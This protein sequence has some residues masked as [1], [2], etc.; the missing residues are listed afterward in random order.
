MS[1]TNIGYEAFYQSNSLTDIYYQGTVLQW[2]KISI[3]SENNPL[4]KATLHCADASGFCGDEIV[5][6]L[7]HNGVLNISGSG[8]MYDYS[9]YS[10]SP[11]YNNKLVTSITI[12]EGVITIGE[13][14]FDSCSNLTNVTIP[15]TTTS[16]GDWAFYECNNLVEVYYGGSTKQWQKVTIDSVSNA[17]L[18]SATLHCAP[19]FTITINESINGHISVDNT[20]PAEGDLVSLIIEPDSCY[21]LDSLTVMCGESSVEISNNSFTMPSGNVDITATFI[22]NNHT[23]S[24]H[25]AIP[26]T[27][28]ATG[29]DAYWSCD[30][31]GRLFSD[32]EGKNEIEEPIELP[33]TSHVWGEA[34]YFWSPDNRSITATHV[35]NIDNSHKEEITVGVTAVITSPTERTRGSAAYTS[36]AF[37]AEGFTV[38]RKSIAIP[39]LRNMSVLYL[40]NL[41]TTI[42]DE[43][44]AGIDC[45]AIVI[46]TGCTSVGKHAFENCENLLYVKVPANTTIEPDAFDGCEDVVVD[47]V[48]E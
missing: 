14:A 18:I 37:N 5:W 23:L 41:L 27:C 19:T 40:P 35:C 20:S 26:A 44:F 11:W 8:T 45:E 22:M 28:L 39:M 3:S 33:K 17:P 9:V 25:E 48:T 30:V 15:V 12:S 2:E 32:E 21:G 31:C 38:Q 16:I 29:I 7:D 42:E 43:A 1:V 24:L 36:E 10:P 13:S 34:S 6:S 4:S 46:P 47:V